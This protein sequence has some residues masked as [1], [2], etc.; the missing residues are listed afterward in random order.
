MM[1]DVRL[2]EGTR[3][4]GCC[5]H[6]MDHSPRYRRMGFGIMLVLAGVIW[7]A[8][9]AGWFDPELFWPVA[10]LVAG[11]AVIALTLTRGKNRR[12]NHPH[13]TDRRTDENACPK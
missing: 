1:N 12:I 10:F 8:S 2:R 3:M 6:M 13:D 11:F 7:L 9:R 4:Y 5:G